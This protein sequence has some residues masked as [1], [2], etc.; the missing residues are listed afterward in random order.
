MMNIYIYIYIIPEKRDLDEILGP[1]HGSR[2]N[3]IPP[4]Q[5]GPPETHHLRRYNDDQRHHEI[6]LLLV[7]KLHGVNQVYR[8]HVTRARVCEDSNQHVLFHVERTWIQRELQL[9]PFEENSLR[10]RRG[11]EVSER[12]HRDLSRD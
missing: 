4:E 5:P 6:Q 1:P 12:D 11:H 2:V 3:Q 8:E 9:S 10:Y 7:E